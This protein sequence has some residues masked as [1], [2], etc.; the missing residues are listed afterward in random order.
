[1]S[2][3]RRSERGP[4]RW[5]LPAPAGSTAREIGRLVSESG[6]TWVTGSRAEAVAATHGL[7]A[8]APGGGCGVRRDGG[9]I[10][11]R[12][13]G[14]TGIPKLVRRTLVSLD[15]VA[16]N[17]RE[18]AGLRDEDVV[19]AVIPAWH[20]YGVENVVL[21]PLVAG[22]T[23]AFCAG[24]DPAVCERL[25]GG[26]GATVFPGVPMM[27]ESISRGDPMG[28]RASLRLA[29]SAGSSL[30]SEIEWA[31]STARRTWAR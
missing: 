19:L 12:T 17:V 22:A 7:G 13:S 1:M 25:L 5:V 30:P 18:A 31:S 8:I 29:Y 6:A 14:T 9:G 10:I 24:F 11:L 23:V 27:F 26:G 20:S 21:G 4:G 15:A 3:E 16:A 2:E 28:A